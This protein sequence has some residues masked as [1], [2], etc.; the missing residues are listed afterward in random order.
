MLSKT[1][2]RKY[3]N[4]RYTNSISTKIAFGKGVE[5]KVTIT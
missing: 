1:K 5:I 2:R 4:A 3:V